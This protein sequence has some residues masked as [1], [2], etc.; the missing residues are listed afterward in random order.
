MVALVVRH[1]RLWAF[2]S[3]VARRRRGRW[4]AWLEAAI[5][6][7]FVMKAVGAGVVEVAVKI[8]WVSGQ[9]CGHSR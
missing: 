4:M 1:R 3:E 9:R 6:R 7:M 5:E 8:S 2:G